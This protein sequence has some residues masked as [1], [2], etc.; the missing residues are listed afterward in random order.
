[1]LLLAYALAS[2]AYT[3]L[4]YAQ[5]NLYAERVQNTVFFIEV[6]ML[7]VVAFYMI[8]W[9]RSNIELKMQE[10]GQGEK[11]WILG[12]MLFLSF[13]SVISIKANEKTYI[14][15]EAMSDI[16]TGKAKSFKNQNEKRLKLY[17]DDSLKEVVVE[18]FIDSPELLQFED[19][20]PDPGEWIN[21][22]VANYYGKESV[23]SEEY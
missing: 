14:A 8:G 3:P 21:R 16:V 20:V 4:L 13:G 10:K 23:R 2:A 7:Y 1:M 6:L 19:N 12:I 5:G 22:V 18:R 9:I 15:S 11:V 17:L